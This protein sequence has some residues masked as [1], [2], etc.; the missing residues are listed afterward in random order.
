MSAAT[1]QK[2]HGFLLMASLSVTIRAEIYPGP[3]VPQ[4]LVGIYTPNGSMISAYNHTYTL[5][6]APTLPSTK[7][8]PFIS[9]F[10]LP[11]LHSLLF[12]STSFLFLSPVEFSCLFILPKHTQSQPPE[13]IACGACDYRGNSDCAEG[14]IPEK[15]AVK[16]TL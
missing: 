6:L 8:S 13:G 4:P 14:E 5:F 11:L 12:L 15:T 7:L 10:T 2:E 9:S 16:R 3:S 1:Y